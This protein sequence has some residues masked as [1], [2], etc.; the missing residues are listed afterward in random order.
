LIKLRFDAVSAIRVGRFALGPVA[1][2]RGD[3]RLPLKNTTSCPFGAPASGAG[4]S[5]YSG[6]LTSSPLDKPPAAWEGVT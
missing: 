2:V 5:A 1:Q 4:R 6:W 3:P